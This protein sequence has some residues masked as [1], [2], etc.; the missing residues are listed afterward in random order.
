MCE[1]KNC[2]CFCRCWPMFCRDFCFVRLFDLFFACWICGNENKRT[3][4][5]VAI[6]VF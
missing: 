1:E 4:V 2:G 6:V 5:S 3:L